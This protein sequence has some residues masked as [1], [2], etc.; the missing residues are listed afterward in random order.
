[1]PPKL[2]VL[3]LW[4]ATFCF[5]LFSTLSFSQ[6]KTINGKIT[7]ADKQ[8]VYGATVLVKGST[9]GV[10]T[11][12]G[13]NF[14]ITVPNNRSTLVVSYVGFESIEIPASRSDFNIVLTDRASALNEVVVTGY[15][16]QRR[17]DITG[18]VAV[19]D[20]SNMKQIPTGSVTQALQGQASGV[21]IL[22]S[23]QPG[24]A[25]NLMIRG[26]TSI[27]S[28]APLIIIDGTPGSLSNLNVNDIESIQVLK[29]A[30]A[31]A[32]YGVRGSNG[33]V[34][35]TTKKGRS[36]KVRVSYDAYYGTQIPIENGKNPF[37]IANTSETADAVFQSYFNS[38]LAFNHKQ[39]SGNPSGPVIPDYLIPTAAMTGNPL[40]D[41]S[42][43]A[44]YSNQITKAN[45]EGTDWFDE[46]FEAAP[47]QS[48]N[49]S[50]GAASDKS[51]FFFSVN[52]FNQQG[53]LL[54]T[55]LKRYSAR[56]N[57]T[58][59]IADHIRVGENA[60]I[61]YRQSPGFTNQNEGNAISMAYR[62]NVIIP[63]FDIM[64]N[65]AGTLSQGLGNAQNPYAIMNRTANNKG[66]N[67]QVTGNI[68]AEV[69]FLKHF[70]ARTSFGGTI[71]NNY[72]NFFTYTSYENAENNTNPNAFQEGFGYNSSWTW[73][74]TLTYQN[75]FAQNHNV[76]VLVGS[77][78]I[79]N[80]GRGINGRRGGYFITNPS[81][82]EVDP[83]LWTLN[84]GPPTGQTT[85]NDFGPYEDALYSLFG[86]VDY[87]FMDKYLLSATVRRD[88]SSVFSEDNRFGVF[89]SVTG[90]WRI[91]KESFFPQSTWLN[92]LKLRGG[93]GKLG[94]I[95]NINP[96]NPYSLYGQSAAQSYY[97]ITG[98]NTSATLGIYASQL[99]NTAT[100]WEEDIITNIGLDAALFNN[101]VDFSIEW[102][103]KKIS[104]LLFRASADP[105]MQGPTQP[106]INV[107][108]IENTG[109]DAS[110]TYHGK[111]ASDW[112]FNTTLT[113][114]SYNN[115]VVSIPAG[116]NYIDFG[117]AGSGRIG[118]FS[119]MQPGQAL[120]A[121][122]GYEVIGLFQDNGDISKSPKQEDAA[123]G[124][125]KFRD[126]D[127]DGNITDDDRTFFG[128]PNPDFTAGLNLGIQYKG[129]DFST[130]L[131]ASVGN[132]VINYVRFWTDFPQVFDGSVSKEAL[133]NSARIVDAQGNQISLLIP[134][135]NDPNKKIINPDARVE[136]P[137]AKVP[138]LERSANFST[139]TQ[140]SSYY[141]ED[142]SFLKMRSL[143][144]GYTIPNSKLRRFG[145]ESLRIYLQASNLFTLTKYKGLDP[146]L[147]N[148][149]VNDN[150]NFG[151]D[152]GN[153]P[154]N[155][156]NYNIG[157]NLTF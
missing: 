81:N 17:K 5:L 97:D 83:A 105:V 27:G 99:G 101:K 116:K 121:F 43:Y 53:T 46:I 34:V 129:F 73:T 65:Y 82:L 3:R 147:I 150:T 20:V 114:T 15:S 67:Y 57:T 41:P 133:Y 142:G 64:G 37:N 77:E 146:E 117:S 148:S 143:I 122:Y 22:S 19:V 62:Q 140:F 30:G 155:Q 24:G 74:N 59:N 119:R 76:K 7:D 152:F 18:S 139:S 111:I 31:A 47:I 138:V 153:Y 100:T 44:L 29:D 137:D 16:T 26:I 32:I 40:T 135:P 88:G 9:T 75:I 95:S 91:S 151:I 144:L 93:W 28:S 103:K 104:G 45:K 51:N 8:P 154:A 50:L 131:Y 52:Y 69:D 87:G 102:Y 108:N 85:G 63:V 156:K 149:D 79:R 11:D 123:P 23:G 113:F 42:K 120:G 80:Y 10:T 58:F 118:P 115:K 92:E 38:N 89:P 107:G 21:T 61:F 72:Y 56:I 6:G 48:H 125:L 4:I 109:I 98:A 1:M 33:V 132:D 84:F 86:R 68:F 36:G 12:E 127:G 141:M 128:N 96:T 124:R 157:I 136:N 2:A 70:T 55:Y 49:I 126:V 66:N 106:F 25:V 71:D 110:L 94:S 35:V 78:S 90:G 112:N 54:N 60:Y 145:I 134:D 39:Y 14:T 130:F 13:G